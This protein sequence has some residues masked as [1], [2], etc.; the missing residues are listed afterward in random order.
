MGK[1][2]RRLLI[3]GDTLDEY[4]ALLQNNE[5][6]G[7]GESRVMAGP[8]TCEFE[9]S[10]TVRVSIMSHPTPHLVAELDNQSGHM[11]L[12]DDEIA[13]SLDQEY[14]FEYSQSVYEFAIGRG[15]NVVLTQR[16]SRRYVDS[17]GSACPF[18]KST[19]LHKHGIKQITDEVV[20][21]VECCNCLA[22]WQ[23]NYVMTAVNTQPESWTPPLENVVRTPD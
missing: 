4:N 14:A 6:Q 16:E 8:F 5:N 21:H 22:I 1:F 15:A 11:V 3:P 10:F 2:Y 7:D 17:G 12:A 9:N 18:C 19:E 23:V 13:G 20:Q